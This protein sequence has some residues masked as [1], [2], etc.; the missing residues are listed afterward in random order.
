MN[1]TQNRIFA[2]SLFSLLFLGACASGARVAEFPKPAWRWD[3]EDAAAGGLP[4]HYRSVLGTWAVRDDAQAWNGKRV[5]LQSGKVTEKDFTR[6]VM[7][8]YNCYNL[9]M[10]IRCRFDSGNIDQA[11]G[12]MFRVQDEKNYY[13]ARA[14]ALEQNVRLYRVVDGERQ[15]LGGD[16]KIP[17]DSGRW[18][19]LEIRAMGDQLAVDWE[20]RTLVTASDDRY[21]KGTIGLWAK[22]DSV[23]A[24]DQVEVHVLDGDAK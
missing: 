3:F 6:V 5:L 24:F 12:I 23:S 22:A 8:G 4:A 11:A 14:N 9:Q 7:D 19:T 16:S 13:L 10:R 20:G 21:K 15:R 1:I 2:G 17:M 18:Y